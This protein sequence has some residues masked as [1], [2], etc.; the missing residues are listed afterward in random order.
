MRAK[1]EIDSEEYNV[2]RE[3]YNFDLDVLEKKKKD[4][5]SII[6]ED[7]YKDSIDDFYKKIK[8]VILDDE[9]SLFKIF[10]NIIENIY[11]EKI[12]DEENIHKVMLHFKLNIL[13]SCRS[14]L[15]LKEF[16]L[17]YSNNDRCS[18]GY[19]EV[20][21]FKRRR[22]NISASKSYYVEYSCQFYI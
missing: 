9:E 13:T 12:D 5:I 10:G 11:V 21:S 20:M 2:Q 7:N 14:S 18:G 3:K 6:K 19:K 22:T 15:N 16:L 8:S 17:L 4:F 1:K